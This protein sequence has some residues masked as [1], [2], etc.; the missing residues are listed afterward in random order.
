MDITNYIT[1]DFK[2]QQPWIYWSVKDFFDD[3]NF[4]HFP[5]VE[6]GIYIGSISP[7]HRNLEDAKLESKITILRKFYTKKILFG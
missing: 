2:S 7:R 4:S 6:E 5:V 1:T 3:L